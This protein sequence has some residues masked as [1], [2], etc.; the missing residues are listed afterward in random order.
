MQTPS[1][2]SIQTH[3]VFNPTDGKETANKIPTSSRPTWLHFWPYQNVHHKRGGCWSLASLASLSPEVSP[4]T[5]WHS[6]GI[7]NLQSLKWNSDGHFTAY[8]LSLNAEASQTPPESHLSPPQN[9]TTCALIVVQPFLF[10]NFFS[11]LRGRQ[12][13]GR[14]SNTQLIM[15]LGAQP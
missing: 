2:L 10:T 14:I 8:V 6:V 12:R 4:P 7:W 9:L 5:Q 11:T 1:G 13:P 15:C 3:Q